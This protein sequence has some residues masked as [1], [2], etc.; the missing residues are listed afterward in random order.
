[1]PDYIY[2]C[3]SGHLKSVTESMITDAEHV[4]YCG[5][6]MWR[7]PVATFVNWGGLRPSQGELSP[8]VQDMVDREDERRDAFRERKEIYDNDRASNDSE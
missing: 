8:E 3:P 2:I 6:K 5:E 7:K 1:M 4:C